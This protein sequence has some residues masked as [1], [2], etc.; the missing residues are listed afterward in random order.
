MS[1]I[2][3]A[4]TPGGLH[5]EIKKGLLHK[6][7]NIPEG[8]HIPTSILEEKLSTTEDPHLRRRIRFA[9]NARKWSHK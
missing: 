1:L 2:K 8:E 5:L 7:L 6:E 3:T 4:F 9:L